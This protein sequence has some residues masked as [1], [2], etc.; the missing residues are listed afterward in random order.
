MLDFVG[1]VFGLL[2]WLVFDLVV[3]FVHVVG[4]IDWICLGIV[5]I[6]V[7]FMVFVLFVKMLMLFDVLF[8][9]WFIVGFGMGWLP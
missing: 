8:G 2:Y 4:Y 6:C 1:A 7:L 9:G 5:T 3:L